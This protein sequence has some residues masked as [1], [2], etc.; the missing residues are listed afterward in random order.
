MVCLD[1]SGCGAPFEES[2]IKRFLNDKAFKLLDKL[3]TEHVIKEVRSRLPK[4]E[5][6]LYPSLFSLVIEDATTRILG[7]F[8]GLC[9]QLSGY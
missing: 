7:C 6:L 9:F 2:E 1:G 5:S 8:G 3:R 4:S